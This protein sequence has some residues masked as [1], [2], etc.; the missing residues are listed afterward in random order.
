MHVNSCKYLKGEITIPGDKS[1]SH[2]SIIFSALSDGSCYISNLGTGR[3]NKSTISIFR[4]MGV[5]IKRKGEGYVVKGVGLNGLKEP[6]NVLNAGNSG[7]TIRIMSGILSA[8]P[9]FSVISG[10][11]YLVRRPMKRVVEPLTKMG[12]K[13]LGR[14]DNTFPPLAILGSKLTSIDY[15]LNV[16]SA[17]VKSAILLAGLYAEGKTS[18]TEPSLSRDHTERFMSFL[19]VP[20]KKEGLTVSVSKISSIPPFE[21][22]VCGDISSAA[23]FMVAATF[24]KGS[25][26]VLKNIGINKTRT[27]VIEVLKNMG[28]DIT[29]LNEKEVCGEPVGDIHIRGTGALKGT[30]IKGDIIPRLIDEIPILAV[31][32]SFAEGETIIDDAEELRVKESDRIKAMVTELQ[33][34]NVNVT[35]TQKGMIIEGGNK[36]KF[37]KI[38]TYGDHR[39]AMAFY[40]FG[41][42]SPTGLYLE[43]TES[44]SVSFPNFFDKMKEVA[45]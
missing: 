16:A 26:L 45:F 30:T 1:I 21:L 6:N 23:F 15:K 36:T 3:D 8:Q 43:E 33:K 22:N 12:A 4:Q 17:Q 19:G 44:I 9:F 25:D 10:D 11:K 20:V 42:C 41:I 29:V 7:T 37:A 14:A 31:A 13:I 2:R 5:E 18:V 28:A 34:L 27:G 38:K 32:A 24:L 35:E 40:I 39:I